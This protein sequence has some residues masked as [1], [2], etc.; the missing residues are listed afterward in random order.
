MWGTQTVLDDDKLDDHNA[1]G[2][3]IIAGLSGGRRADVLRNQDAYAHV[4]K[5]GNEQSFREERATVVAAFYGNGRGDGVGHV[6][7]RQRVYFIAE[8]SDE[9]E[10]SV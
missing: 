1:V 8:L 9:R 4:R 3:C 10:Q 5:P 2:T 6:I 7:T